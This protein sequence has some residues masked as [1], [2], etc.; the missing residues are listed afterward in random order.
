MYVCKS[1]G[2]EGPYL[3]NVCRF[4][5]EKI[6][7]D[8]SD[9]ELARQNLEA[10][11]AS[12]DNS[13]ITELYHMLAD[14]GEA[15]AEREYAKI[16]TNVYE[17]AYESKVI[18]GLTEE[19]L[20]LLIQLYKGEITLTNEGKRVIEILNESVK[21]D[22]L[23]IAKSSMEQIRKFIVEEKGETSLFSSVS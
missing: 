4:C 1:C 23:E 18:D 14:A 16:S 9:I 7:F 22:D 2:Q 10:A 12:K 20:Q 15:D 11:I 8:K 13:Y 3:G 6:T 17:K 21:T 5:E 19:E